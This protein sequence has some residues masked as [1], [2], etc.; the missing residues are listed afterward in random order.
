GLRS[1]LPWRK[2][3]ST[4]Q[5]VTTQTSSG[6]S[7]CGLVTAPPRHRVKPP[8]GAEPLDRHWRASTTRDPS[9]HSAQLSTH[10]PPL[11]TIRASRDCAL[12]NSSIGARTRRS[13]GSRALPQP[14]E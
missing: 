13:R 3:H 8:W 9:S 12:R 6:G 5:N 1:P 2:G 10:P 11:S 7:T 14:V 4:E